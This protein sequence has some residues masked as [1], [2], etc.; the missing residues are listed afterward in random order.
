MKTTEPCPTC[1]T[2][3][4]TCDHGLFDHRGRL[5]HV[6]DCRECGEIN[7]SSAMTVQSA[8][9]CWRKA[10]RPPVENARRR[11]RGLTLVVKEPK[12]CKEHRYQVDA[13]VTERTTGVR[14]VVIERKWFVDLR[15]PVKA[16]YARIPRAF[17]RWQAQERTE[18]ASLIRDAPAPASAPRLASAEPATPRTAHACGK[19][20]SQRLKRRSSGR[21]RFTLPSCKPRLRV[22]PTRAHPARRDEGRESAAGRL[23]N[24]HRA[25]NE[26]IPI[27][28]PSHY[29]LVFESKSQR[30]IVWVAFHTVLRSA[31]GG[32]ALPGLLRGNSPRNVARV[33][34]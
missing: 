25:V 27:A 13:L 23:G 11:G 2:P 31:F 9:K 22:C 20:A 19:V 1:G 5:I 16:R 6:W 24:V 18:I 12:Q 33:G 21:L 15:P 32:G 29:G 28:T 30:A 26:Q 3:D 8:P 14:G 7:R 17:R 4:A 34:L 10:H